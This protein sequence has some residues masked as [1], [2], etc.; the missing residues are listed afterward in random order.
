MLNEEEEDPVF[1]NE[2]GDDELAMEED[3]EISE[4]IIG[5]CL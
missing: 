4:M 2:A 5:E 3:D 1:L